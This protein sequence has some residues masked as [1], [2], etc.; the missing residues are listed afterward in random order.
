MYNR[1][2]ISNALV[3]AG[4]R[5]AL[6]ALSVLFLFSCSSKDVLE[7]IE[8]INTDSTDPMR[9]SCQ[10]DQG[11]PQQRATSTL[12]TTDFL[13]NTYKAYATSKQ[14]TV[15]PNY[16]VE[17]YTRG[18]AWSGTL[19]HFWD[20]TTIEGQYEK[21]W[22]Y[23]NFPYRFHAVAP[24]TNNQ[25][26]VKMD[27]HNLSI[28]APYYYQTCLNGTVQTRKADCT[29]TTEE[30]EPY[31]AAQ[32]HR[33]TDGKDTDL[34]AIDPAKANVNNTTTTRHR[35]VWMP[36][37]HLNSKI[38]FAVYSLHPWATENLLYIK[39]L[40]IKVTSDNFVTAATGYE[41]SCGGTGTNDDPYTSWR[42]L[43]ANSGF[44]G[45]TRKPAL[46]LPT[47]FTFEG[48]RNVAGNDLRLAQTQKTAFF[49]QCTEGIMQL[50]QTNVTMTV[51]FKVY[52]QNDQVYLTF[53][54]VPIEIEID[55]TYHPYHTWQSGYI[56]TY[57]LILG[58]IGDKLELSFT[59]TLTPWEYVNGSLSTDLEH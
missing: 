10:M 31:I 15:M 22:D 35:E 14:Q 39:D 11:T 32:V 19:Q 36:F 34:L 51:S 2:E 12:L 43:S 21:F 9:F 3:L 8:D 4:V 44:K 45:L 37:H 58:G 25:A 53:T 38:R 17:Y 26:R 48:G 24:Y 40:T 46:S 28:H 1:T 56:Y 20:Y 7:E 5:V 16:H 52:D 6:A 33:G 55:G 13:V 54:D 29:L 18:N 59:C 41:A 47:L 42:D 30:A 57:Y 27:D 50:P 49:L 23:S